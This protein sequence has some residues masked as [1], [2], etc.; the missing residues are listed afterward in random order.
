MLETY[1]GTLRGNRIA[2]KDNEPDISSDGAE[3]EVTIVRKSNGSKELRPIGLAKGEFIVP[4]GFNE[5]LPEVESD[6]FYS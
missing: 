1:K 3:V 6:S 5:P 2:W 4:D